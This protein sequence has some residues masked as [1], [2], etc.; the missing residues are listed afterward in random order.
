MITFKELVDESIKELNESN[1]FSM[2]DMGEDG[3][4]VSKPKSTNRTK[5]QKKSSEIVSK[6]DDGQNTSFMKKISSLSPAACGHLIG[7]CFKFFNSDQFAFTFNKIHITLNGDSIRVT[8]LT[9]RVNGSGT[10]QKD[11]VVTRED[12]NSVLEPQNISK[13]IKEI[14][15]SG[16]ESKDSAKQSSYFFMTTD[17]KNASYPISSEMIAKRGKK[18]TFYDNNEVNQLNLK[19]THGSQRVG[20]NVKEEKRQYSQA[21]YNMYV[22][23]NKAKLCV[24]IKGINAYIF[25]VP[26]AERNNV[27]RAKYMRTAIETSDSDRWAGVVVFDNSVKN[28]A[29]LFS[30]RE[31]LQMLA[32]S[33][34][35]PALKA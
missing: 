33:L 16:I 9:E 2:L 15:S 27:M 29:G 26:V 6:K 34:A 25:V 8:N 30:S 21:H 22:I 10:T 12:I 4:L 14:R 13:V 24:K 7:S 19:I 31:F 3:S 28:G 5:I 18:E 23:N 35:N 11:I 1:A 32:D 20:R 17:I